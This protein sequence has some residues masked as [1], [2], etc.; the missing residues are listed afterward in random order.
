MQLTKK[1]KEEERKARYHRVKSQRLVE[2][3][4][5]RKRIQAVIRRMDIINDV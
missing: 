2:V 4:R 5:S 3:T 1:K